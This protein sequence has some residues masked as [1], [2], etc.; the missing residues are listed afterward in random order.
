V[1]PAFDALEEFPGW[2]GRIWNL[3]PDST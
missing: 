1:D 2:C 3:A